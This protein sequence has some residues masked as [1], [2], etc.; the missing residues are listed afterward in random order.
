MLRVRTSSLLIPDLDERD[1][2]DD[3]DRSDEGGKNDAREEQ[4]SLKASL[5]G[6]ILC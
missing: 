2:Q 3:E 1:D 5:H 4:P 6:L